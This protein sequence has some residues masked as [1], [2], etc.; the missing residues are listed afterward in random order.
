M[1]DTVLSLLVIVV[2]SANLVVSLLGRKKAD[3]AVTSA[4]SVVSS[5]VKK[6]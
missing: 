3:A 6:V 2:C 1:L 4:A 5:E